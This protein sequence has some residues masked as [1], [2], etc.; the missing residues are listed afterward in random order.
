M[1]ATATATTTTTMFEMFSQNFW[2]LITNTRYFFY[3]ANPYETMFPDMNVPRYV[4]EVSIY[5]L[6]MNVN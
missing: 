6:S 4:S 5:R 3:L 1:A 2:Q